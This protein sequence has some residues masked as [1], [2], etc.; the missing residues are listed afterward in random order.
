MADQVEPVPAELFGHGQGVPDQ[1]VDVVRLDVRWPGSGRV[2]PLVRSH[3]MEAGR[4]ERGEQVTPLVRRL[5]E[6]VEEQH[7]HARGRTCG[8]AVEDVPAGGN[9]QPLRGER[10]GFSQRRREGLRR[11]AAGRFL[12]R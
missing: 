4:S 3:G 8:Q 6:T 11:R 9:F 5:G 1:V 10:T 7:R 2:P 12:H